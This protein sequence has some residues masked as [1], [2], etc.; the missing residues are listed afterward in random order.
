MNLLGDIARKLAG[1]SG[2]KVTFYLEQGLSIVIHKGNAAIMK[3]IP[4]G[5][6]TG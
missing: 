5:E 2:D 3:V 6:E 1:L 4:S